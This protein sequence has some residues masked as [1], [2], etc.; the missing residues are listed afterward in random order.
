MSLKPD[1]KLDWDQSRQRFTG[2]TMDPTNGVKT[3]WEQRVSQI[4]GSPDSFVGST[5]RTDEFP[6]GVPRRVIRELRNPEHY[7]VICITG[8]SIYYWEDSVDKSI[9]LERY[10]ESD[11]PNKYLRLAINDRGSITSYAEYNPV[12]KFRQLK[13]HFF[14]KDADR[15]NFTSRTVQDN[16]REIGQIFKLRGEVSIIN[17][18]EMD[19]EGDDLEIAIKVAKDMDR[20][21]LKE[22]I[23]QWSNEARDETIRGVTYVIGELIE[24]E[25]E[26]DFSVEEQE[27]ILKILTVKTLC[28]LPANFD[29]LPQT[30]KTL[31]VYQALN[32]ALV[33][34]LEEYF[35]EM[36]AKGNFAATISFDPTFAEDILDLSIGDDPLEPSFNDEFQLGEQYIYDKYGFT[37][38]R[39][40]GRINLAVQDLKDTNSSR[41]FEFPEELDLEQI[42]NLISVPTNSGWERVI[43]HIKTSFQPH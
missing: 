30:D 33:G 31:P 20:E 10:P 21:E 27:R 26:E 15:P 35:D 23:K 40:R 12:G 3:M 14:S 2:E 19:N 5:N 6:S 9:Y 24:A 42:Y 18:S 13:I 32:A 17:P 1:I 22:K 34:I 36:N 43:D 37:I 8:Y 29:L 41:H 11:P 25:L 16:L 38:T 39:V 28:L 4:V 7:R